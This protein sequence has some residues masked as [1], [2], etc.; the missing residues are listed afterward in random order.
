MKENPDLPAHV[1]FFLPILTVLR[2]SGGSASPTELKDDLVTMLEFTENELEEKLKWGI[3]NRQYDRLEQ[4]LS[5]QRRSGLA[6]KHDLIWLKSARGSKQDQADIEK[7][8]DD[9]DR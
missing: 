3:E 7:L 8:E 4:G 2:K 5:G 9:K 1:Q 6:T